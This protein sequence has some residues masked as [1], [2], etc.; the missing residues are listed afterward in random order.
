MTYEFPS[1]LS[2]AL[3]EVFHL[4]HLQDFFVCNSFLPAYLKLGDVFSGLKLILKAIYNPFLSLSNDLLLSPL[5]A[6]SKCEIR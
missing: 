5:G 3:T 1:S 4:S 2:H 6:V